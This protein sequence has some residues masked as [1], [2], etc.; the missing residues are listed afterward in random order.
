MFAVI[1]T[2]GKQYK[3]AKDDVVAIE[4]L[5]GE[6]GDTIDFDTVMMVGGDGAE[7]KVG[8]PFVSGAKVSAE[9]VD[10]A[11][12]R[13]VIVFKKRRRQNSRRK[14]GHRQHITKVRITDIAAG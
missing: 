4:K 9:V 14:N 8:A 10:Q 5:E 3:V 13:K 7:A 12:T 2:G 11:R 1:K 6:A